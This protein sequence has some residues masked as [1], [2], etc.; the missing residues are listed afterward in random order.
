MR[1]TFDLLANNH[2]RQKL[3]ECH[4]RTFG[5]FVAIERSFTRRAFAPAFSTVSIDHSRQNDASFSGAAKAGFEE[6]KKWQANLAQFDRLDNQG[7]KLFLRDSALCISDPRLQQ[8]RARAGSS[9]PRG[10]IDAGLFIFSRA[11]SS[12]WLSPA[13]PRW[14]ADTRRDRPVRRPS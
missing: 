11:A 5:P 6:V 1:S 4:P 14:C 13:L 9:V 8:N 3:A 12:A 7:K 10:A 2:R